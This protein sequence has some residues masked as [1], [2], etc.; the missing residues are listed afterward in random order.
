ME[1]MRL[2]CVAANGHH[3]DIVDRLRQDVTVARNEVDE[4]EH[5]IRK[6]S[7]E[8]DLAREGQSDAVIST[9]QA[10]VRFLEAKIEAMGRW[11]GSTSARGDKDGKED[12]GEV[13]NLKHGGC[14]DSEDIGS[15]RETGIRAPGLSPPLDAIAGIDDDLKL[16]LKNAEDKYSRAVPITARR[17]REIS[18]SA[19]Q[20]MK[21]SAHVDALLS[22]LNPTD[23]RRK[24]SSEEKDRDVGKR[25]C[26]SNGRGDGSFR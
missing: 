20:A 3:N 23:S 21:A 8:L 14:E 25:Q 12:G 22:L 4:K 17:E 10:R 26:S 6:L 2:V 19:A 7:T 18:D 11:L 16:I 13:D 15:T 24:R 5:T 1:A 9:K